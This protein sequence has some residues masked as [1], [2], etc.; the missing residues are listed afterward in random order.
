MVYFANH[1]GCFSLCSLE[2][3]GH[4]DSARAIVALDLTYVVYECDSLVI[5]P[6]DTRDGLAQR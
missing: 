4:I 6:H 3:D 2:Y 5:R 1:D